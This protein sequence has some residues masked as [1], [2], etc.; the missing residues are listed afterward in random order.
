MNRHSLRLFLLHPWFQGF[1]EGGAW[2]QKGVSLGGFAELR[3][4]KR[5]S[6]GGL[7]IDPCLGFGASLE[8]PSGAGAKAAQARGIGAVGGFGDVPVAVGCFSSAHDRSKWAKRYAPKSKESPVAESVIERFSSRTSAAIPRAN[9]KQKHARTM[10][11]RYVL[12]M[13]FT[14]STLHSKWVSFA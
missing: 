8:D 4:G 12:R 10:T 1:E 6:A 9:P 11:S 7:G 13:D 5:R 3:G 14:G 2:G